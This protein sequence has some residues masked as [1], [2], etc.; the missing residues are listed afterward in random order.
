[1]S[2][3]TQRQLTCIITCKAPALLASSSIP[4]FVH[5]SIWNNRNFTTTIR[6]N[7]ETTHS[8]NSTA[9]QLWTFH[10]IL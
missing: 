1:V 2:N 10:W 5:T 9:R 7:S 8:D 3:G 6:Q 4:K